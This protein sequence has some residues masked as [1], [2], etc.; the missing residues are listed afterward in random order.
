MAVG[1]ETTGDDNEGCIIIRSKSQPKIYYI[2]KHMYDRSMLVKPGQSVEAG[3]ILGYIWGD[4]KWS[5]LHIALVCP[6][7]PIEYGQRYHNLLN[8]FCQLY[9]LW[10][11]DLQLHGVSRTKG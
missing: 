7:K 2:Y 3:E 5:H 4:W 1:A 9:E 11:G 8:C 6:E 10:H